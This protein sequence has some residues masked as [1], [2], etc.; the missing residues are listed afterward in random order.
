[1]VGYNGA[2][3]TGAEAKLLAII[4]DVR[5]VLGSE[6]L[7]TIPTLNECNLR[8]YIKEGPNLRIAPIPSVYF[9]A[10]R[11]LVKEHDLIVLTEG[12]T[13]MDTWTSALLWAYLWATRC[14]H[15]MGKP[16]LAYA[17][18]SGTLS[19]FNLRQVRREASKTDLIIA[20]NQEAADSLRSWGVTSPIEVTADNAFDF[21]PDPADGDLLRR[22]WPEAKASVVGLAM[23]DFYRWPVHVQPWG[24]KEDCYRWPYYFSRSAER[25]K[26]ADE[27]AAGYAGLADRLIEESGK[28]V[29]LFCMEELDEPFARRVQ[30]KMCNPGATRIFSARDYNASQMTAMLR[31]LDL[32]VT[33]RYHA[34]VLSLAAPVPQVAVGHDLR[35]RNIYGELGIR[36]DYFLDHSSP[37]LFRTLDE[38]VGRLLANST[39]V[40][41]VLGRGFRDHVARSLRN[42]EL[43][44]TFVD[45][46][47]GSAAKTH[48]REVSTSVEV[49]A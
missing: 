39:Q 34:C 46:H 1:M 37:D 23:V 45:N 47:V 7:I 20:R 22:L 41:E 43:L 2:N 29:A 26:A 44:R 31:S 19:S 13:Y 35:L 14:A 25:D 15:G 40:K 5:A 33:S 36:D 17:V 16:C 32:L 18:D 21:L 38:R 49:A 11:R 9:F 12:S 4:D 24:R 6:A 10:I 27:L 28:S 42:R 3:N 30:G 48:S 8:R